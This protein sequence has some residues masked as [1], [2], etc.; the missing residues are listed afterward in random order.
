MPYTHVGA[1][2]SFNTDLANVLQEAAPDVSIE[3]KSMREH[4]TS[5]QYSFLSY[6]DHES[7]KLV[8]ELY[9]DDFKRLGYSKYLGNATERPSLP[10]LHAA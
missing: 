7:A 10:F 4:Q 5:S 3:I 6:F 9:N 8:A 2:E 1:F